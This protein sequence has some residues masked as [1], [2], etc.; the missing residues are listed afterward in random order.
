MIHCDLPALAILLA[1]HWGMTP[2]SFLINS[3]VNLASSDASHLH[4]QVDKYTSYNSINLFSILLNTTI[5]SWWSL[6]MPPWEPTSSFFFSSSIH[7]RS[8]M[9]V[10][11]TETYIRS[12]VHKDN[13]SLL[14]YTSFHFCSIVLEYRNCRLPSCVDNTR[15]DRTECK[16]RVD[17]CLAKMYLEPD[18]DC[19]R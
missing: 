1:M 4:A 8:K 12:I 13:H 17:D 6:S 3:T 7:A 19:S 16:R 9:P 15:L 2:D 10:N 14:E 18:C 11:L 5:I